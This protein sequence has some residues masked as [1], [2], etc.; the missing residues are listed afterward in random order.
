M[1]VTVVEPKEKLQTWGYMRKKMWGPGWIYEKSNSETLFSQ[2]LS[3]FS[4]ELLSLK[5]S[6]PA[7]FDEAPLP[8]IFFCF[9]TG[10]DQNQSAAYGTG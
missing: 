3:I 4:R 1:L 7:G 9:D 2:G 10:P 8:V 6:F 5:Q